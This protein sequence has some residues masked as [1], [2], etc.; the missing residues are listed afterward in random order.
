VLDGSDNTVN[1]EA[2]VLALFGEKLVE[3]EVKKD[4]QYCE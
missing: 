2:I 4:N 3:G 1:L